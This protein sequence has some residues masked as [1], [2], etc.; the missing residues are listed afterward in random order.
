MHDNVLMAVLHR[1]WKRAGVHERFRIGDRKIS[2]SL[3]KVEIF[4]F[5]KALKDHPF[6]GTES[7]I[8]IN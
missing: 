1:A 3:S 7:K 4:S 8:F 6:I 2:N 5:L